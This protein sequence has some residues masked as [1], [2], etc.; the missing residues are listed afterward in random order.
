MLL[1]S[2]TVVFQH[3]SKVMNGVGWLDDRHGPSPIICDTAPGPD[4]PKGYIGLSLGPQDPKGPPT[5]CGTHRVDGGIWSFRLNFVKNVCLNYYSW[6]LAL[7][8]FRDDNARVFQRVSMNHNMTVGPASSQLLCRYI[9][10]RC[11]RVIFVES[12][13]RALR[14]RV[15]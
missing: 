15:I 5:N 10:Q 1:W 11:A 4:L 8:N 12:E 2:P 9:Q 7:F 6:N 3:F 13:S 14:V